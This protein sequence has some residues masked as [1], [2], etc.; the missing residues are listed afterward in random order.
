VHNASTEPRAL[1]RVVLRLYFTRYTS[2]SGRIAPNDAL[3]R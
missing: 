2:R 1:D 3:C